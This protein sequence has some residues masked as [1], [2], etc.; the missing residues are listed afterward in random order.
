MSPVTEVSL[1]VRM[2]AT[3]RR[4]GGGAVFT[5][6]GWMV[7]IYAKVRLGSRVGNEATSVQDACM[8][9]LLLVP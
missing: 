6:W 4:G 3:N 8:T 5:C 9:T 1:P 2:W 7:G